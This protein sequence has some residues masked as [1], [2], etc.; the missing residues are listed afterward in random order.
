MSLCWCPTPH[1]IHLLALVIGI[2][3]GLGFITYRGPG[4]Q[5]VLEL[6]CSSTHSYRQ[7]NS[8][9]ASQAWQTRTRDVSRKAPGSCNFSSPSN[10]QPTTKP[11]PAKRRGANGRKTQGHLIL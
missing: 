8:I 9:G 7:P 4:V 1:H 6:F 10:L 2:N 5:V 3:R 11:V